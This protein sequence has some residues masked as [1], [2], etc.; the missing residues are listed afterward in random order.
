MLKVLGDNVQRIRTPLSMVLVVLATHVTMYCPG[1]H[2]DN[3]NHRAPML[4]MWLSIGRSFLIFCFF[5]FVRCLPRLFLFLFFFNLFPILFLF[6]FI[7]PPVSSP[8]S[9][10][11]L[12][13]EFQDG[14]LLSGLSPF[15]FLLA[16]WMPKTKWEIPIWQRLPGS[17][18]PF[19][20]TTG[21]GR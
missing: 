6:F 7:I 20:S 9:S 10:L 2:V 1:V 18:P 15:I 12:F 21:V 3:S 8:C 14:V 13:A 17:R 4:A 19:S 11:E 16:Q 5:S